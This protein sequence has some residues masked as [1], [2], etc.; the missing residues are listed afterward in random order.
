MMRADTLRAVGGWTGVPV[1]DELAALAAISE[2][3]DGWNERTVTWL[4]RKHPA[5]TTA[6]SHHPGLEDTGRRIALQR[7]KALRDT[8][9]A[10][11]TR[12]LSEGGGA[13]VEVGPNTKLTPIE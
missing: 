11:A 1:D 3:G 9:F 5:Q 2:L 6:N 12:P 10:L 8:G 7:A 13:E 4:Y